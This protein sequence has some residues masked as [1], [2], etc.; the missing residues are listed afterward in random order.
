MPQQN[1]LV[2]V[3]H[4][5]RTWQ[6]RNASLQLARQ[7]QLAGRRG[8]PQFIAQWLYT[9]GHDKQDPARALLTKLPSSAMATM[10]IKKVRSEIERMSNI[11]PGELRN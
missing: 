7:R 6:K 1:L 10:T 8:R 11:S 5:H 9:E 2:P 3:G 4:V